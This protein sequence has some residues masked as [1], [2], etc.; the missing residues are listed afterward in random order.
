VAV[1]ISEG[2]DV[3]GAESGFVLLVKSPGRNKET[4]QGRSWQLEMLAA[5]RARRGQHI[6]IKRG[7]GVNRSVAR[8]LNEL[9]AR[10]EM[11]QAPIDLSLRLRIDAEV[12]VALK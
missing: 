10:Q 6:T 4:S 3:L 1:A 8:C 7:I 11:T 9:A 5:P 2:P 12:I